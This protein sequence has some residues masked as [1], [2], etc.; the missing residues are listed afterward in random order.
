MYSIAK[1]LN[2]EVDDIIKEN[3]LTGNI[4]SIGQVLLIPNKSNENK[5]EPIVE[6]EYD[7]YDVQKGDSLWKIARDNN[8]SVPELIKINNLKDLT[9]QI[10]QKLLVP[11]RIKDYSIY[12]VQKGDTL[13]SIAKKFNMEVSELK[14]INN[15]E[16]NLLSIGQEL[17]INEL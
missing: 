12:I 2:I 9:L 5:E 14:Q 11:K 8:I 7:I 10:N 16:N 15:I 17:I 6:E 4:L 13:W 1:S 3:N